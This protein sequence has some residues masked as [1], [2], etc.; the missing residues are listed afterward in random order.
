MRSRLGDAVLGVVIVAFVLSAMF[1]PPFTGLDTLPSLGVVL[2][3]LAILL[4]DA[5]FAFAGLFV[6]LGGIALAIFAAD[7]IRGLLH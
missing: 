4:E 6:G 3:A 1:S 2:I 7:A 5:I